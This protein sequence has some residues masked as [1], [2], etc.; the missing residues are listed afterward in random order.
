VCLLGFLVS[1]TFSWV[2][3][4]HIGYSICFILPTP[5]PQGYLNTHVQL[6]E[7]IEES[8]P[9]FPGLW[10]TE[11]GYSKVVFMRNLKLILI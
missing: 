2:Q 1:R 9:Q 8:S 3:S 5:F 10:G 6:E 4:G 11:S 7:V